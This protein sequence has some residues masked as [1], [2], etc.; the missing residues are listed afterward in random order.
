MPLILA[1]GETIDVAANDF[2]AQFDWTTASLMC[3]GLG[4]DGDYLQSMKYNKSLLIM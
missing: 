3:Q 1:N 4:E 2:I